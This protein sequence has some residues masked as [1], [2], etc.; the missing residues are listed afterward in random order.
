[1]RYTGPKAR[2]C[3]REGVNLFGSPKYTKVLRR[4]PGLPGA[5]RPANKKM[6]DF[7]KQLREKQKLKM[8]YGVT[9]RQLKNLFIEAAHKTGV[10][11]E[12]AL[13]I[14]ESRLDNVL[15]RAGLAQTR[16]QARQMASHGHFML[17]GRR[18]DIPSIRLS[19][20]DKLELRP[21][22]AHSP[23]YADLRSGKPADWIMADG[24]NKKVEM[25]STPA[26][27]EDVAAMVD[28]KL[29]LEYYS[30]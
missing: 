30:R 18:V 21:K 26:L 3:R 17:N 25:K 15:Y 27:P 23:L 20:G 10:T 16:I 11:T 5:N 6:S 24:K 22:L 7:G 14:L 1:M 13:N 19:P 4:R 2:I 9:E 29:V 12:V 28:I 8:I